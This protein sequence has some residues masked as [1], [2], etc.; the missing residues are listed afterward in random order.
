MAKKDY[1]AAVTALYNK[2]MVFG[3]II[4]TRKF[5]MS[6]T[7]AEFA[8]GDLFDLNYPSF[9][10]KQLIKKGNKLYSNRIRLLL[11][12]WAMINEDK[13]GSGLLQYLNENDPAYAHEIKLLKLYCGKEGGVVFEEPDVQKIK[14]EGIRNA[15]IRLSE[16]AK[17]NMLD[18]PKDN[19][20]DGKG[21]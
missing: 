7:E 9:M 16:K 12:L 2:Y 8:R 4:A 18:D 13:N 5:L 10:C 3:L 11:C 6:K 17:T 21:E 20:S 1:D 14:E 19:E 15:F